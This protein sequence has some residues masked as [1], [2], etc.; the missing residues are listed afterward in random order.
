MQQKISKYQKQGKRHQAHKENKV[1]KYGVIIVIVFEHKKVKVVKNC[2]LWTRMTKKKLV[3][4]VISLYMFN[5][6]Y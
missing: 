6:M 3:D 1:N 4:D 2:M 5:I